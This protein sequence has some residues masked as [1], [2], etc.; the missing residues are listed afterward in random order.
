MVTDSLQTLD[1]K[2]QKSGTKDKKSSVPTFAPRL[3]S[4]DVAAAYLSLGYWT[5]RQAVQAGRIPVVEWPGEDG[6]PIR[7]V[8]LDREDLDRFVDGLLRHRKPE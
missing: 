8:L 4:L 5:V 1:T 6:E 3:M 7:R 2:E